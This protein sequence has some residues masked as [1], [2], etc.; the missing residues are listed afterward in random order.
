MT[1]ELYN[2]ISSII[3]DVFAQAQTG[4][5]VIGQKD[6]AWTYCL[7]FYQQIEGQ[8]NFVPNA[9]DPI[10]I[11]PNR[12]VFVE[13]VTKYLFYA[14]D[15]YRGDRSFFDLEPDDFMKKLFMDLF[16]SATNFDLNNIEQYIDKRTQIICNKQL[17]FKEQVGTYNDFSVIVSVKQNVSNL[18]GPYKFTPTLANN[19]GAIFNLPSVT[20]GVANNGVYVYG[21]QKRKNSDDTPVFAEA[22]DK[23]FR[24]VNHKVKDAYRNVSPNAL[25]S[26]TLFCTYLKAINQNKIVAPCFMPIRYYGRKNAIEKNSQTAEELEA[27]LA[28]QDRDQTNITNKFMKLL[29]R[30]CYHFEDAWLTYNIE[31]ESMYMQL[32]KSDNSRSKDREEDNPNLIYSIANLQLEFPAKI[33][34]LQSTK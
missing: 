32:G 33:N 7:K 29:E 28:E 17:T 5:I 2:Y 19:E 8:R 1:N 9:L 25:V 15:F 6:N 26:F 11:I 3:D 20:F 23:H 10:V 16:I 18:E 34:P 21:V 30:Y 27:A 12:R 13:K 31:T 24:E 14:K 22:L 4:K